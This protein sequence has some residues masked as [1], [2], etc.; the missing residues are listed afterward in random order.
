MQKG[1][2][3]CRQAG[4]VKV[5]WAAFHT[6]GECNLEGQGRVKH[7]MLMQGRMEWAAAA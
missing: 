1:Q 4:S 3:R 6:E 7:L 5:E 2:V